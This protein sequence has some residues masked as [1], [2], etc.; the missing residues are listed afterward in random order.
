M[1]EIC[2]VTHARSE[3]NGRVS[4]RLGGVHVCIH[5]HDCFSLAFHGYSIAI[6]YIGL[7]AVG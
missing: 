6:Q 1:E 2:A 3:L 4:Y 5:V 7:C